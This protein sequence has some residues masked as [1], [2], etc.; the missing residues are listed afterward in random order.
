MTKDERLLVEF[1]KVAAAS[2]NP[3]EG[4]NPQPIIKRLGYKELLSKDILK[5]LAKANFIKIYGPEEIV[6]T[7]GGQTLARMLLTYRKS[8]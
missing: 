7:P 6:V 5:G 2:G 1:F 4:I 8:S 3:D